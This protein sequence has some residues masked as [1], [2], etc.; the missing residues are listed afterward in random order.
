MA[1]L[2]SGFMSGSEIA[3]FSIEESQLEELEDN[4]KGQRIIH[5]LL[6][7]VILPMLIANSGNL[8][9][10][11]FSVGGISAIMK[12]LSPLANLLVSSSG[13]VKRVVTKKHHD[14]TTDELSHALEITDVKAYSVPA[15]PP[16]RR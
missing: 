13:I 1:L 7:G 6:F 4:P 14:V 12:M 15:T 9:W 3:F 11:R 8:R 10:C 16:P 2:L 5:I